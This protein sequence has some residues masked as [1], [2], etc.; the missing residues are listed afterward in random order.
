MVTVIMVTV[1]NLV[2]LSIVYSNLSF[3]PA[4]EAPVIYRYTHTYNIWSLYAHLQ[5]LVVIR[6][7]TILGQLTVIRTPTILGQLIAFSLS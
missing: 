3:P 6:T 1:T 4:L 5:Y 7:P 2:P